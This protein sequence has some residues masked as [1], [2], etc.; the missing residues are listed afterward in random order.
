MIHAFYIKSTESGTVTGYPVTATNLMKV[1]PGF[2]PEKGELKGWIPY[3]VREQ[4]RMSL[5]HRY[6]K[7]QVS[8]GLEDGM[9]VVS[10]V[11]VE[12]TDPVV[13]AAMR[14]VFYAESH[15]SSAVFDETIGAWFRATPE[16]LDAMPG[17]PPDVV[18]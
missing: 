18:D 10:T 11:Y 8:E 7:K 13:R 1:V 4:D 17:G 14:E 6:Y 9:Y 16:Q 3:V 12:V 15:A 2:D 5:P